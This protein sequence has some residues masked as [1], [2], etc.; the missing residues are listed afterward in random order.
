[1]CLEPKRTN[2]AYESHVVFVLIKW[3]LDLV[4]PSFQSFFCGERVISD[5]YILSLTVNL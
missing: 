1:M 2:G 3:S 5:N 4:C